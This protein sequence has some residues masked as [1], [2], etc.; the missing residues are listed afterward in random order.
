MGVGEGSTGKQAVTSIFWKTNVKDKLFRVHH[1]APRP[2][3]SWPAVV[4]RRCTSTVISLLPQP[5]APRQ[6]PQPTSQGEATCRGAKETGWTPTPRLHRGCQQGQEGCPML[7]QWERSPGVW[8]G[9]RGP[10]SNLWTHAASC[11]FWKIEVSSIRRASQVL[12]F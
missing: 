12:R 6:T 7:L 5:P 8:L 2:S 1:V 3:P 11:S 10:R 4:T 9:T